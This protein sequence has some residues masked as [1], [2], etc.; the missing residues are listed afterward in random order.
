MDKKT[1][2]TRHIEAQGRSGRSQ[3]QY[4]REQGL[5]LKGFGYHKRRIKG[6]E[7][8]GFVQISGKEEY[9]EIE[10]AGGVRVRVPA[11]YGLCRILE[12]LS[13]VSSK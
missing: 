2:W 5:D 7:P 9:F 1:Q 8:A 13:H 6:Q 11:S 4:C 12:E 3:A 10:T